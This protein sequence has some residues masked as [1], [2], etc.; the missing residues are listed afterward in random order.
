[1]ESIHKY[2]ME[3]LKAVCAKHKINTNIPYSKLSKKEREIV[4]FDFLMYSKFH[5]HLMI[6]M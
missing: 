3:I 4:L 2:Y 6:I 5:S 1:M